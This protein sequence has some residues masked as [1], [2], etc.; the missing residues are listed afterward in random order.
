M[1]AY[2]AVAN[3]KGGV[4]KT[5]TTINL[6]S[7][8]GKRDQR[9]LVV[10]LDPQANATS[11]LGQRKDA[12]ES[13]Y[14]VLL[15]GTPIQEAI[16]ATGFPNL[17]LA[18]SSTAMAGVEVELVSELARESRL[19]DA[20]RPLEG[21]YDVILVDC[22]PSLGLL[23]VNALTACRQV[24]IP[25]QCEYFA[26]EGL[27]QLLAAVD[28]VRDRLNGELRVFGVVMTMEDRRNRLS[29]QVVDDVRRH[30]PREVFDTRIPR[31]VR[32]AEAPSYGRPVD[33]Y[34]PASRGA[35]AYA[36]LASEMTARLRAELP[37]E[38]PAPVAAH[39]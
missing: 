37:I 14:Q 6:G 26:L 18:R 38:L 23:T 22:P 13:M 3:Q 29:V 21:T 31:S 4:G 7:T 15:D 20:L 27:A 1:T 28:L 5:T 10:D 25:L 32:L 8:L 34:D 12:A 11:G 33:E 9:V 17:D 16:V 36:A 19:R 35:Q 24:L 39:G 2:I 30:F